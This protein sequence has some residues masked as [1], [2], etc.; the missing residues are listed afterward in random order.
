MAKNL[1][2]CHSTQVEASFFSSVV[3]FQIVGRVLLSSFLPW[4]HLGRIP[5]VAKEAKEGTAPAWR[6]D[7]VGLP[8]SPLQRKGV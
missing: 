4:P 1:Q 8:I 6:R 3:E 2:A 7:R 5:A